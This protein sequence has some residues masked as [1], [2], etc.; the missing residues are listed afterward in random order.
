MI[1]WEEKDRSLDWRIM[2][3][4]KSQ[5]SERKGT[6]AVGQDNGNQNWSSETSKENNQPKLCSEVEAKL[7]GRKVITKLEVLDA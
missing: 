6:G 5:C 1:G 2:A 7:I 4:P 3:Q